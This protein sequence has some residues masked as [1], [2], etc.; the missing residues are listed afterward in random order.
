MTIYDVKYLTSETAKIYAVYDMQ[1]SESINDSLFIEY[2]V[3]D[4]FR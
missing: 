1:E 3:R 4:Y 2:K